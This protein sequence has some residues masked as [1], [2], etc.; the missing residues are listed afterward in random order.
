MA[1]S[2]LVVDR[3][4]LQEAFA[5]RKICSTRPQLAIGERDHKAGKR[6]VGAQDVE[7]VET[8]VLGDAGRIDLEVAGARRGEEAL[9]AGIAD[10]LLVALLQLGLEAVE[11]GGPHGDVTLGG[12]GG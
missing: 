5:V 7:A 12:L 10:Q 8:G 3:A 9:V 1:A 11:D 2:H 6:R 4:G